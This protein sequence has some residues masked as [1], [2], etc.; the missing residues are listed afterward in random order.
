VPRS[1]RR[2]QLI[3]QV[4]PATGRDK[5]V[6]AIRFV[7]NEPGSSARDGKDQLAL[8]L[9]IPSAPAYRAVAG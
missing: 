6:W 1:K 9:G 5:W 8:E 2:G 3:A 4:Y 7:L